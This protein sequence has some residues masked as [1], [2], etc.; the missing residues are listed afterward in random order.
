V[1]I[2]REFDV[3]IEDKLQVFK[4]SWGH[5]VASV[6]KEILVVPVDEEVLNSACSGDHCIVNSEVTFQKTVR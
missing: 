3:A 2:N 6:G 1:V 5:H 4:V